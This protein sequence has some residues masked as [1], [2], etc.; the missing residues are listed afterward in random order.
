MA[1]DTT[2][3]NI[4]LLISSVPKPWETPEK[5]AIALLINTT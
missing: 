4:D 3:I 5:L 2:Y 1:C